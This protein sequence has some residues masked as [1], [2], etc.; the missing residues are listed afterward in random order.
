MNIKSKAKK[1]VIF[2]PNWSYDNPYQ[3]LLK[4]SC[5]KNH[6]DVSYEDYPSSLFPFSALVSSNQGVNTI[7]IHWISQ[8]IGKMTWSENKFRFFFKCILLIIDLLNCRLRGVKLIWTIHNKFAHENYDKKKE[9]VVRKIF[10]CCV[11]SIILHS[12]EALDTISSLYKINLSSKSEIVFH[13][14][15]NGCYPPPSA[16][17]DS[18]RKSKKIEE[19]EK[20]I[21][22]F[23]AVKPYKG[24]E[25]LISTFTELIT[26]N[27]ITLIIAGRAVN[28]EYE[29]KLAE[30][31]K[32]NTKIKMDFRYLSKEE[33]I[34]YISIADLIALPFSD[35]LTSGTTLLAMN[36]G[37]AL[38][39]PKSAKVFGCVPESGVKYFSSAAEVAQYLQECTI[40]D[41]ELM[42]KINKEK[43]D[44]MDWE[45]VG[46]LTSRLY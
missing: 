38:L 10:A 8:I 17:K 5:E 21:L 36:E 45:T 11:T 24:V 35:T 34:D 4:S 44:L 26:E 14:N 46:K 19:G 28:K 2:V 32:H 30:M 25:V 39:L 15:F 3:N 37:K 1:K 42:G 40:V 31:A 16:A 43:S 29:N 20:I 41:L 27:N 18:L 6:C 13:G 23:G 7:H 12:K 22:F 9:L 33:L